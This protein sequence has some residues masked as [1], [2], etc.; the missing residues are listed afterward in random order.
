MQQID[1]AIARL[2]L[3]LA[4]VSARL[5]SAAGLERQCR[6]QLQRIVEHGV[7]GEA[8]VDAVLGMLEDVEERMRSAQARRRHLELF[9]DAL[10]AELESLLLTRGI[11]RAREELSSL[12]AEVERLGNEPADEGAARRVEGLLVEIERLQAAINEASERAARTLQR[13]IPPL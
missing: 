3:L 6:E 2:R 13:R 4:D 8:P 1:T 12:Q 11:A 7:R 5:E 9:R 10:S